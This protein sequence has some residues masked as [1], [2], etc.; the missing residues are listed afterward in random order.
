MVR[1]GVIDPMSQEQP[2]V[3][4]APPAAPASPP[5]AAQAAQPH[6]LP[7]LRLAFRPFYVGAAAF[8]CLSI[9]LWLAMFFGYL[10]LDAKIE[11]LLWHAHEMLFGFAAAVI[12][13]FLMTA[14]KA[15]TGLATP[16][17]AFLGLLAGL[18]LAARIAAL[19]A[20][21]AVYA[22]LDALLLPIVAVVMF[23][24]LTRAGSKRNLPFAAMLSL[25]ALANLG[26]HLAVLGIVGVPPMRVL[27][28]ALGLIVMIECMMAGRVIPFFTM[29]ATPGL[30]LDEKPWIIK[31]TLAAS[32]IGLVLWV[33]A[34]AGPITAL[35]LLL[36]AA[37][38]LLRQWSWQPWVTRGRPILWILHAAYFWLPIGFV[39]LALAQFGWLAESI[40]VHAF[41]VGATGGL[42][43][44]MITRTARGHV[45]RPLKVSG[46]EV[47][48]YSLVMAAAVVRVLLPAVAPQWLVA[49]LWVAAIAWS[50]AFLLYL[51]VYTPWLMRTRFDGKDG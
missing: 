13:G 40:G 34:P 22:V 30:K 6:G 44:G 14:G 25:L 17:G 21:Y 11:P 41:A 3:P 10:T 8:A 49:S 29:S 47:S 18:W 26:F 35:V 27:F 2:A 7:F 23:E 39:L 45:G 28:A 36:A 51:V 16:R 32:A 31:A 4:I 43:I 15:W 37:G 9:P 46:V 1:H 5:A 38:H 42:I 12:M 33:F 20:P 19:A 48:A 24:V 50:V